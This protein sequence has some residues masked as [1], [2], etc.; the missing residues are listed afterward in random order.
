MAPLSCWLSWTYKGSHFT[1][2]IPKYF[3]RDVQLHFFLQAKKT[4]TH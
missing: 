4:E 1:V 3:D 2:A